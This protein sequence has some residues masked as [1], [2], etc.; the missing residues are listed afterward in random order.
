MVQL[1]TATRTEE[2]EGEKRKT[3][4]TTTFWLPER[5]LDPEPFYVGDVL[6]WANLSHPWDA[7][8]AYWYLVD[9]CYRPVEGS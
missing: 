2:I 5:S 4:L 9:W 8:E 6:G 7:V 1:L 3:C